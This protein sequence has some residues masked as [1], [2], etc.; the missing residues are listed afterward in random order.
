MRVA[1]FDMDGTLIDS[2]YDITH[3]INHVRKTIYDLEPLSISYV[4]DAINAPKR[5]LSKLFYNKELYEADA[6]ECFEAHY[7]DQCVQNVRLYD[8]V[9]EM[10]EVLKGADVKLSVATNAPSIF[11]KRML[12]HLH[13]D[14]FFDHVVGADMV[15]IPK[16]DAQMLEKI[17][18][19]YE[20]NHMR[21]KAWMV[22][23]NSKDMLSAKNANISSI[24]AR[25]GFSREG[26]GD[27]SVTLPKHVGEIIAT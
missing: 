26:E 24:F 16:P 8:G 14:S 3:S 23:D 7:Y 1:I 19:A 6:Q 2:G 18:T 22:G 13:V 5:N 12:S 25:W 17:L 9:H 15:E 27:Y 10:L 4:V 11:A 20:F 21:D